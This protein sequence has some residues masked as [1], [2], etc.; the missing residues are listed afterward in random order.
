MN[1]I[2][3]KKSIATYYLHT[4][5]I[6]TIKTIFYL[7]CVGIKKN[8]TKNQTETSMSNYFWLCSIFVRSPVLLT[9]CGIYLQV[10]PLQMLLSNIL[11]LMWTT[12]SPY[13]SRFYFLLCTTVWFIFLKWKITHQGLN[14][15]TSSWVLFKVPKKICSRSKVFWKNLEQHFKFFF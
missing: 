7:F 8:T 3:K 12:R 13:F 14:V 15:F 11:I 6:I 2:Q 4:Y 1:K 9:Y 5:K 10:P